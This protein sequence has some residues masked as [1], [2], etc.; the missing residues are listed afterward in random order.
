MSFDIYDPFCN[1]SARYIFRGVS[2]GI[3]TP[4]TLTPTKG[5]W[6]AFT[7]PM[8]VKAT[9]KDFGGLAKYYSA[10]AEDKSWG[11][12]EIQAL[13]LPVIETSISTGFEFGAD[14]GVTAGAFTLDGSSDGAPPDVWPPKGMPK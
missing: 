11:H 12:L 5:D 8:G 1:Q 2:L 3:S 13:G 7:I 14:V 4:V 10:G 6:Q 9:V